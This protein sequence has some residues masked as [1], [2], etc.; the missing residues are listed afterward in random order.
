LWPTCGGGVTGGYLQQ[1][2]AGLQAAILYGG[3]SRENVFDV[4]GSAAPDGDV[5]GR[6][7]EAQAFW[8]WG[9]M[10]EKG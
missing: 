5:S 7:A 9:V 4:D 6:D 2:V 3:A 1:P 10:G 8:T